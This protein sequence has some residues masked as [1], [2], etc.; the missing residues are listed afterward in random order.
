MPSFRSPGNFA[1]GFLPILGIGLTTLIVD[2]TATPAQAQVYP[3]ADLQSQGKRLQLEAALNGRPT[4][5]IGAFIQFPDGRMGARRSELADLGI[6]APGSGDAGAVVVLEDIPGLRYVY[7]EPAQAIRLEAAQELLADR[8]YSARDPPPDEKPE[9]RQGFGAVV[10]YDAYASGSARTAHLRP[11]YHGASVSLDGRVFSPY[12]VVSQSGI[13]SSAAHVSRVV[14][15]DTKYSYSD[16]E[17]LKTYT[18]G[19][20]ISSGLPWTRPIRLG[21]V[22][23]QRNFGLRPDLVTLPLAA[24]SGNAAVPSTLDVYVNNV[25][26]YTQEIAPGPYRITDLPVAGDGS[27]RLVLRDAGGRLIE[28]NLQFYSSNRMLRPGFSDYSAEVG[29]PR[30]NYGSVSEDYGRRPVASATFRHG[31]YDWLTVEGHGEG[32]TQLAN[33]GIGAAARAFGRAVV[34]GAVAGSRSPNGSGVQLNAAVETRIAGLSLGMSVQRAF[35]AYDDLVS[36]TADSRRRPGQLLDQL[37]ATRPPR[38][39]DRLS[40]GAPLP[41]DQSSI[42]VSLSRMIYADKSRAMVAS[43]SWSRTLPFDIS[44]FVTAFGSIGSPSRI[45]TQYAGRSL[46]N[47]HVYGASVGLSMPLGGYGSVSSGANWNGGRTIYTVDASKPLDSTEGSYGW[48]VRD[49]EGA[50]GGRQSSASAS[51]RSPYARLEA[52]ASAQ[53]ALGGGSLQ[54]SGA[55]A[56][57][58][59]GVFFANRIDDAFAVVDAGAP[60][61]DVY[62]ENRL[63]GRTGGSGRLLVPNLRSYQRNKLRIDSTNLPLNAVPSATENEVAPAARSGVRVD[64]N[65]KANVAGAVVVFTGPDGKLLRPGTQGVLDGTQESFVVGYDGRAYVQGLQAQNTVT[66]RIDMSACRAHF[67]YRPLADRQVVI[68]PVACVQ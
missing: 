50:V 68:G 7:D 36:T 25:K 52:G 47:S 18:V 61:V 37:A 22:Q 66:M 28:Q 45:A 44:M 59:N 23:A 9:L 30:R 40:I 57:L 17:T 29:L 58:G 67:D 12:G 43:A 63:V 38:E 60:N 55:I 42:S 56:S 20:T 65:S 54:A 4:G 26:T 32:S 2:A 14:R 5:L 64:F 33:G 62:H 24:A 3:T 15:L 16:P 1:I 41:F 21:G 51:W 31:L 35:G 46:S 13:A 8:V 53:G 11:T 39:V 6:R 49:A 10:N 19:D 48:R 27:A 34:S